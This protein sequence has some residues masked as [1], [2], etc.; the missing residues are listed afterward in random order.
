MYDPDTGKAFA[1]PASLQGPP[2]NVLPR[3]DLEAD[4][5]GNLWILP[6]VFSPDANGVVGFGRYLK[7]HTRDRITW[8]F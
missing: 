5:D 6:P 2:S 7:N 4:G 1:E 3:L 8:Y